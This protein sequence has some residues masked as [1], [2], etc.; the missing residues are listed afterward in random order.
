MEAILTKKT[1]KQELKAS[2]FSIYVK[3]KLNGLDKNRRTIADKCI[4]DVYLM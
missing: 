1:N 2:P 3:E 4:C